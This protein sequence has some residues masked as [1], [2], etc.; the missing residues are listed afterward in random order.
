MGHP[1]LYYTNKVLLIQQLL[2]NSGIDDAC[3][4]LRNTCYKTAAK[5]TRRTG[6]SSGGGGYG[7]SGGYNKGAEEYGQR[8][9]FS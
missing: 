5:N 9:N 8:V 7:G 6:G 3:A 2:P 1:T 4:A